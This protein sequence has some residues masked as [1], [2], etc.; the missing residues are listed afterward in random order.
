MKWQLYPDILHIVAF[1]KDIK[2]IKQRQF[3]IMNDAVS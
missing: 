1:T 2:D 3:T